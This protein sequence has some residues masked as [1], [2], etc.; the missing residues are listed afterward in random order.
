MVY[1]FLE[2][3]VLKKLEGALIIFLIKITINPF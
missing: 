1:T 3:K 2:S